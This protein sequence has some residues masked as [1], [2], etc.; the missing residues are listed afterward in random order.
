MRIAF[1]TDTYLPNIDGVV[2]AI[3][4]TRKV[5]EKFG[6][7]VLIFTT[8]E[9]VLGDVWQRG[10]GRKGQN[11]G[12]EKDP[13]VFRY[14]S[15]PFA[16]YPQYR[17]AIH[18]HGARAVLKRKGVDIIHSHG[19]G[20]MGMAALYCARR[21]G[22]P[23]VGTL[24]TNIQEATHYIWKYKTAQKIV[25]KLAKSAAW[26]YLRLYYNQ[27]DMT[28]VPSQ[29]ME[30]LCRRHGIRNVHAMSNGIDLR[31]FKPGRRT[32]LKDRIVA[33][34]V[35]RLVKEKNLDVVIK[36]A[37]HVEERIPNIHFMI[38]GGGPAMDYYKE[39]T[40]KYR[41]GHL[42]TFAG[43]VPFEDIVSYYHNADVFVF[44]SVFETQGLSGLEAM[45]TGLPVAGARALAIPDFVKDGYNGYLFSPRDVRGCAEAIVKT[46]KDRKRLRKGAIETAR[47]H[48][49]KECTNAL[50][51]IY[52]SI[53]RRQ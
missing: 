20:P 6:H 18:A 26:R 37:R 33:L 44:P 14:P 45:A 28:L 4:N 39:L 21:L 51:S 23:I 36:A 49:L 32:R 48:S 2:V 46:I 53:V 15:I 24:H 40:T 29:Y 34:Y 1:F 52:E 17:L 47:K 30:K 25:K 50:V 16:P 5:L 35:G 42:F 9:G 41:V 8:K 22:L 43:F 12:K 3:L 27:C 13:N 10:K 11:T 7:K 38:V 19:M 31:R